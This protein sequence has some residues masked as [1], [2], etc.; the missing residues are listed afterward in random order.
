MITIGVDAHRQVHV[1]VAVDATGRELAHWRG[2][3][4]PEAWH[5]LRDWAVA[6]GGPRQW[7]IEGAWNYGRGLARVYSKSEGDRR[8]LRL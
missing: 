3:N 1:A 5:Q 8:T 7:G 4:R 6:L 2:P